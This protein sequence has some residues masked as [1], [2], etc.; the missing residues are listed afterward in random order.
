MDTC[1]DYHCAFAA[2]DS[3]CD[4]R[5][6]SYWS[7]CLPTLLMSRRERIDLAIMVG[8]FCLIGYAFNMYL[9]IWL[10]L[11]LGGVSFTMPFV[12]RKVVAGWMLLSKAIGYLM[13]RVL[14]TLIFFMVLLPFS[15]IYKVSNKNPLNRK[16][17][18]AS[19]LFKDR[20]HL[21]T[22]KDLENP[23]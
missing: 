7:F 17:S 10:A 22:A 9:M 5:K 12:G 19:S 11:G 13:S 8:G 1:P 3:D 15:M 4:W 18:S 2:W 21:Y 14:L 23:W 20:G 6:F 16:S